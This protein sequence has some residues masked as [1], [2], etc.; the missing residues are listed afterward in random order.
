MFIVI[1]GLDG[2]GKSTIT[3]ALAETIDA[4]VLSTP[5]K[6]FKKIREQ[7]ES[8]YQDNHQARQLFYM[9]TVV[10]VS[11]QVRELVN[12]GKNVIVDRYWLSTQVYHQWKSENNHFELVDVANRILIPDITIYLNLPLEHR[13]DRLKERKNN[14]LEDNLTLTKSADKELNY[15]Y[16][17]LGNANVSGR[18]ISIKT[19]AAVDDIVKS[20]C[21]ELRN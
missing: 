12:K 15:L 17:Q 13:K 18:W 14:T 16:S 10:S 19:N 5:G 6:Q 3:Q 8:I 9:S 21:A 2:V 20:I 4:E 11:E 1:E 7:L